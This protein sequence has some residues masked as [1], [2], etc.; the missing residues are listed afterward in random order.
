M[1]DTNINRKIKLY[2]ERTHFEDKGRDFVLF[3]LQDET[4][5]VSI[6]YAQEILKPK[7]L[8]EIPFTPDFITGVVNLRGKI[9]PVVNLRRRFGMPDV[10][11]GRSTRIV[12]VRHREQDVGLLVDSVPAVQMVPD[13]KIETTPDIVEG[14]IDKD[15]FL[16]IAN[17]DAGIV[18]ILDLDK[19]IR[20][21]ARNMPT[22][23]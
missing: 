11:I 8:T 23:V 9:V 21:Q 19:A 14:S 13:S 1:R 10:G 18:T 12:V 22:V 3:R 20:K 16:G 2:R 4:Y 5:A 15:Y 6:D 7:E 17:L